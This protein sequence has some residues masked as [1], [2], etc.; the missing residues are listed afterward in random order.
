MCAYNTFILII[1]GSLLNNTP[2]KRLIRP[3]KPIM[4]SNI[5]PLPTIAQ[6]R[7]A[8]VYKIR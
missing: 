1:N 8:V 5:F 2:A 7:L 6:N 4:H 3:L